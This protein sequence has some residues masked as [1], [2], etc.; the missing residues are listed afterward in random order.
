M[1]NRKKKRIEQLETQLTQEMVDRLQER[2]RLVQFL[3]QE[4]ERCRKN[5]K[6]CEGLGYSTV[7]RE[8][9]ERP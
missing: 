2:W 9:L 5:Y 6:H 1:F 4:E 3:E 8:I 7:K